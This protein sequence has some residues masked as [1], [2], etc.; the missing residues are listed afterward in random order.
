MYIAHAHQ[1]TGGVCGDHNAFSTFINKALYAIL[2][3]LFANVRQRQNFGFDAG[4]MR[5][6]LDEKF[7]KG[8]NVVLLR[9]SKFE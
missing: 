8:R 5:I 7:D 2:K 1:R 4:N 6:E 3:L 9:V